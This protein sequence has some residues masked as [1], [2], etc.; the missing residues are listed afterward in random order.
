MPQTTQDDA[1]IPS[2]TTMRIIGPPSM[3]EI[4]DAVTAK[5]R[6]ETYER[7]WVSAGI[8]HCDRLS[9]DQCVE[10]ITI[11]FDENAQELRNFPEGD[12]YVSAHDRSNEGHIVE[13]I[14]VRKRLVT[15]ALF[16]KTLLGLNCALQIAAVLTRHFHG[17][18]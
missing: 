14:V 11:G 2:P 7:T 17:D 13:V 8:E 4:R 10:W 1:G 15:H 9:L 5:L 16:V 6:A 18:T 3:R 12:I